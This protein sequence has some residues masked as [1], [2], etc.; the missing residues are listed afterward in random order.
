MQECVLAMYFQELFFSSERKS[1]N[2]ESDD[3][4]TLLATG[5]PGSPRLKVKGEKKRVDRT[6]I[7]SLPTRLMSTPN[8]TK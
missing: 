1:V 8:K 5:F 4:D 2:V 7:L 6:T 3:I